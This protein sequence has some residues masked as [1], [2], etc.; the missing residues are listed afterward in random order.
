MIEKDWNNPFKKK[1][2]K[3]QSTPP[4]IDVKVE[5]GERVGGLG[6]R[7]Q[8]MKKQQVEQALLKLMKHYPGDEGYDTGHEQHQKERWD[9]IRGTDP[10]EDYNPDE[11]PAGF[12]SEID[13]QQQA[14]HAAPKGTVYSSR[15]GQY[16]EAD[17]DGPIVKKSVTEALLKIMKGGSFYGGAR[18]PKGGVAQGKLPA[19]IKCMGVKKKWLGKKHH[20]RGK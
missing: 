6:D 9:Y 19:G 5:R 15:G 7:I 17:Y 2:T 20:Y 14:F 12:G 11:G 13:A 8:P 1:D 16:G 10:P 3:P 18:E 4:N